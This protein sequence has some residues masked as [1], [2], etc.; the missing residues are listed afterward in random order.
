MPSES[1]EIPV[2]EPMGFGAR[3]KCRWTL[4]S[5]GVKRDVLFEGLGSLAS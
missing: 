5:L 3:G 1:W 2:F 4:K